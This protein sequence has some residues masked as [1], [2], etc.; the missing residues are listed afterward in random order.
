MSVTYAQIAAD[1]TALALANAL[2][3]CGCA[4]YCSANFAKVQ[5]SIIHNYLGLAKTGNVGTAVTRRLI[6]SILS[7][8][9]SDPLVA[10]AHQALLDT[11]PTGG[12]DVGDSGT[13]A[14]LDSLA[15]LNVANGLTTA[16][17]TAIKALAMLPPVITAADISAAMV[18][19]R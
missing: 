15:S 13:Q 1:S 2:N 5:T 4:A 11:S 18:G 14:M 10:A 16:D 3:D 19:H 12:V 8:S 7:A 6:V 9:S 17:A